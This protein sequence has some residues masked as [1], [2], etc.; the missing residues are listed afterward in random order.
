[1][2]VDFVGSEILEEKMWGCVVRWLEG[3][4]VQGLE[5]GHQSGKVD[6]MWESS[7]VWDNRQ[8]G[9]WPG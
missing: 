3:V 4:C 7:A 1:M 5:C 9:Y 6:I 2:N 8:G